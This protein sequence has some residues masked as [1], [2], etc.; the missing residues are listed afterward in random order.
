M[1]KARER[2]WCFDAAQG[3]IL[4]VTD[5]YWD[6]HEYPLAETW[7]Y[8]FPDLIKVYTEDGKEWWVREDSLNKDTVLVVQ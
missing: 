1:I 2:G 7:P 8:W 4:K 6:V 3:A 5:D